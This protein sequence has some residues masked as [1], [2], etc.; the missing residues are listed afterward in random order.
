[1]KVLFVSNTSQKRYTRTVSSISTFIEL[2][3]YINAVKK[4]IL[5]PSGLIEFNMSASFDAL[6]FCE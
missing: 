4:V 6:V 1:M 2:D 3:G 5:S